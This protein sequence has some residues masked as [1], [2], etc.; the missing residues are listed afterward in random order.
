MG[1]YDYE[2]LKRAAAEA[3]AGLFSEGVTI[4]KT[5]RKKLRDGEKTE[6][7]FKRAV[8]RINRYTPRRD[9]ERI[10]LPYFTRRSGLRS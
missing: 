8:N 9:G 7:L 5:G 4:K 1:N 6:L 3:R 2:E 10:V